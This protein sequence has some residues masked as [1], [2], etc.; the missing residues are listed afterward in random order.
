MTTPATAASTASESKA[1]GHSVSAVRA[2]LLQRACSCAGGGDC[3]SCKKKPQEANNSKD[4]K[5]ATLQRSA[6]GPSQASTAPPVVSRVLSSP[7]R[8]LDSG[9][10]SFMEPR[11]GRDF[12][13][14]RV[15][16]DPQAAESARA[17][18]AHA[19]TV[20]Q[21]VVFDSGKYDPHTGSGQKLLA[22]ELAHTVQ[23]RDVGQPPS[24]MPLRETPEYNHLENEAESIAQSV[25]HRGVAPTPP[26][27][28]RPV[29]SRVTKSG[30]S[31]TPPTPVAG[32]SATNQP[33]AAPAN[34]ATTAATPPVSA[35]ASGR[36]WQQATTPALKQAGVKAW[37]V[38]PGNTD[39][40]AVQMATAFILPPEKGPVLDVWK[41]QAK[42]A[43]GNV[44]AIEAV[45]EL[46]SGSVKSGLKQDSADT[47]TKRS[48]WLQKVGWKPADAEHS[49][50]S[51]LKLIK[52]ARAK[53]AFPKADGKTC[54]LD[55]IVELQFGGVN[56]PENMQVLDLSQN[57][58]SG[59]SIR[60]KLAET[61]SAISG[62]LKS[63]KIGAGVFTD[64]IIQYDDVTQSSS[65]CNACCDVERVGKSLGTLGPGDSIGKFV[66]GKIDYLRAGGVEAKVLL[67]DDKESP[68]TL[69]GSPIPENKAASTLV[70]GFSLTHWTRPKTGGGK[71]AAVIGPDKRFPESLKADKGQH[72][73]L[74]RA[75]D[76]TL[77]LPAGHKNLKFHYDFLSE[78]VFHGLKVEEGKYLVGSGTIKPS[79]PFFSTPLDVRFDREKFELA[80]GIPKDKLKLPIPGVK[81]SK[82]EVKLQ[83]GPEFKPEGEVEFSLDAG[84]RHLLDGKIALSAD[85]NGLVMDG[86]VQVSLPGVD[87]AAGHI[88]YRNKQWSGKAEISAIQLQSKLKYVKSG[89]VV[90]SFSSGGM[91]AD[92]KVAL[93]LPGPTAVEAELLYES[94]SRRWLFKGTGR[95]KPP[96]LEETTIEILYDGEHLHGIG[97][98]GFQFR[99][100][101]GD[102]TVVYH[103]EKFSG[104][105]KLAINKGK[106]KGSLHVKMREQGGHPV[107]SGD[108]EISYQITDDLIA[109]AGI[110]I[111]E[112]QEVRLKGA[113][114][115]PK[116]IKLFDKTK[117][118]YKFFEVGVS[119]PIP[120]ASIG[121][122]GLEAR[123][124]GSLSAGY[125]I[126][127]GELRNTK[128][129]AAFN[130][131]EDKPDA[132]VIL[133]STLYIGAKAYIS[134][135]IEGSIALDAVV[136]SVE[137]GLA[138]TA[139][140]S[141]DG[142]VSSAVTL[143]YQKGRFEADANLELLLGLALTLALDAFVKAEAGVW[144]FKVRTRKDWNLKTFHY[145][146]G[147]QFGMKL[148]KP[149]HYASDAPTQLPSL[150][151][152]QWIKPD[153]HPVD[154]L[155]KIFS[156][157]GGT[158]KEE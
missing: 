4:A 9:A 112:K 22:H 57:R 117:G 130:P 44:K 82:A 115:F 111:N 133:T 17:V 83:L 141:L 139:T 42:G 155:E 34:S 135:R 158:E 46:A 74:D 51:A 86:D 76:G 21:H 105:G 138:I 148:K 71:V 43:M 90:V 109:T 107:F 12:S 47:D 79:I 56:V 151:D 126:G 122:V 91:K 45:V 69:E 55:H 60:A 25:M 125:E 36:Q 48:L 10:R 67:K 62:A 78:G 114:E 101:H 58:S 123:I 66:A 29:L 8:P 6:A 18:D 116:P 92:G 103:D 113:L 73:D 52:P 49:W 40:V 131:L 53:E 26:T 150:D 59:S 136:A 63:D 119:I 16:T 54:D 72:V 94:A 134:G 128:I 127:P 41:K 129:E 68:V 95:F 61:A 24:V 108:G 97:K 140:A 28:S 2:P 99:G 3:E 38:Q 100:I 104:E 11:F 64:I 32:A 124:D 20:G 121:P 156:G 39:V 33:P 23:Q 132:D 143:H 70:A 37:A 31:T 146:T 80:K 149:I 75:V 93:E 96:G 147:L 84:K 157:A 145:D 120:G 14:V 88:E 81:V 27:V 85:G 19:Y 142:H 13:S 98:T 153:I 7:G 30:T 118:D 5:T 50:E 102:I 137:G 77:T 65:I 152:I 35:Q 106:A 1:A 144:K 89:S 110:L 15:H 87:N 154:M